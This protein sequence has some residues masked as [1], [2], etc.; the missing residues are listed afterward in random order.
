MDR[1]T[2]AEAEADNTQSNTP[3]LTHAAENGFNK[4]VIGVLASAP[5]MSAANK[6]KNPPP[7]V[8]ADSE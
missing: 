4:V 3:P 6:P 8:N 2:T 7:T 5:N 1:K